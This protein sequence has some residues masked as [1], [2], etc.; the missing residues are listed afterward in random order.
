MR[1]STLHCGDE[2]NIYIDD[3]EKMTRD[4]VR[5]LEDLQKQAKEQAEKDTLD[6]YKRAMDIV[7]R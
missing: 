2:N 3:Y 4:W 7:R 1:D 5:E 6:S